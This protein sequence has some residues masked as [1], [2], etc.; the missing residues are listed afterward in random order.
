MPDTSPRSALPAISVVIPHLNQ[1]AALARCLASLAAQEGDFTLEGIRVVDNGST[2]LPRAVCD[3]FAGVTLLAE[4]E[5]GPG[6]ARN[7]GV[8]AAQGEILAFIDAD[9]TAEPGWLAAITRAFAD[10]G[11]VI[12]GGD[13]R[14]PRL[15]H[16]T[17]MLEAYESIY[18]YRM[19]EYIARQGFTGTGNLAVRREVMAAVGPFGGIH[20][21][22]DRDWGQRALARG[23]RTS[24]VPDMV[25]YHPARE[26]FA[27]LARK[28]DR[29]TGHDFEAY[30]TRPLGRLK[31]ALRALA[32]ACSPL[33][34]IPRLL[35]S[36]RVAGARE[37]WLAFLC[38]VRIRAYRARRMLG[39]LLGG[40]GRALSGA[41]NR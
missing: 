14:I 1:P 29:S 23:H 5:P 36:P 16:R 19:Q 39:L 33:A 26:S 38:L 15:G 40:D 35:S 11:C 28:W 24:Y 18:A 25:I 6:P 37:R 41:W 31:W 4:S 21:A 27:E 20:I 34:E 9:C 13:V 22:E 17:T 32:V 10:P 7:R 3:G 30:R 12:I 8:A 2:A